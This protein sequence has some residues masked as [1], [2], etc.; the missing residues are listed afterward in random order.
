MSFDD[1]LWVVAVTLSVYLFRKF[2]ARWMKIEERKAVALE[3]I[4]EKL[5][6]S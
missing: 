5:Q 4:L 2:L 3:G 6:D 1:V